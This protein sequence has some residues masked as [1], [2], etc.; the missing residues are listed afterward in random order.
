MTQEQILSYLSANKE[1]FK[2]IYHVNKIGIFGS[3]ARNQATE[4][5]DI[6]VVVDL[7]KSTMFGLVGVKLDIEEHFNTHVDIVQVRDHMNP[8]LKKRIEKEAL[9]V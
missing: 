8:L 9:Y 7:S 3:F 4:K 5:S 2:K 1:R 6:D